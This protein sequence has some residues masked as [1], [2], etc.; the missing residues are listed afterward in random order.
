[1]I[2]NDAFAWWSCAGLFVRLKRLKAQFVD[3]QI[4]TIILDNASEFT[5]KIFYD[6][7]TAIGIN[8]EHPI[9]YTK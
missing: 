5:S 2:F 3:Y 7:C 6:Y 1:M 8:V 4:K 9:P